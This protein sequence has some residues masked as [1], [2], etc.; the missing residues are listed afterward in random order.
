MECY[1]IVYRVIMALDCIYGVLTTVLLK[2]R[3]CRKYGCQWRYTFQ[4]NAA[5]Q[6]VKLVFTGDMSRQNGGV[7]VIIVSGTFSQILALRWCHNEHGGVSNHLLHN[8]VLNC[9]FGRRSKET[10]KLRVTGLCVG[11][12]PVTGEFPTQRASSAENISIWWRHH[13]N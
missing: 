4:F 1:R 6:I 13:D 9:L 3:S 7:C 12:S 5:L 11:N 8:C 2:T 10:S